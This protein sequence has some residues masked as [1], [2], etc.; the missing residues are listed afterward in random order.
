[1]ILY[2]T[3]M[4][5]R[6]E[7]DIYLANASRHRWSRQITMKIEEEDCL[8]LQLIKATVS[9]ES[10]NNLSIFIVICLLQRCLLIVAG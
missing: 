8:P 4:L 9:A 3:I 6:K 10:Y 1:M 5:T 2:A 7:S